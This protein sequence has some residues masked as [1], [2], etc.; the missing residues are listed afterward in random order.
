MG[1]KETV[2]PHAVRVARRVAPGLVEAAAR[3]RTAGAPLAPAASSSGRE[4]A[5]LRKRVQ[6]LEAE[7]QENRQLNLRLAE[8][9]DVVQELLLPIALRDEKA[10]RETLSRHTDRL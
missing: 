7:V 8:L 4:L 5:D 1:F 2:R 9:T 6:E 3:R 10:I